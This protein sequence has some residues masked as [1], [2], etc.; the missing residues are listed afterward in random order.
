MTGL[1]AL[2]GYFSNSPANKTS[3]T[4]NTGSTTGT[5]TTGRTLFP[6]QSTLMNNLMGYANTAMTDPSALTAPYQ[7][8]A[9]DQ[10]DSNYSGLANSLQQQFLSTG[11]GTSGKYGTALEQ[12][13]LART[14]QLA[15]TDQQFAQENATLPLTVANSLGTNLMNMNFGST[16]SNSGTTS[17]NGTS[18]AAGS[19][20]AGALQGGTSAATQAMIM[21]MLT[22]GM[23]V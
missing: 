18:V 20:L 2:T 15:S 21:A 6:G 16:T 22:G 19:P 3:T 5:S 14:G 13:N 10:V 12:G 7:Q 17:S 1:S 9:R 11:G 23:G 4:S 8:A